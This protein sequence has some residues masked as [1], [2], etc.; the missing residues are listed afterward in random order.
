[1]KL[2]TII[3]LALI[4]TVLLVAAASGV[5]INEPR[6][7]VTYI[8]GE[9]PVK[10]DEYRFVLSNTPRNGSV[11]VYRNGMRLKRGLDYTVAADTGRILQFN[12]SFAAPDAQ[13][14]IVV[15]YT[16]MEF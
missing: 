12:Q 13:D 8:I 11:A 7:T 4:A 16:A 14:I 10:V 1:M 15:D 3:F 5:Q 6:Y 2:Y 9:E